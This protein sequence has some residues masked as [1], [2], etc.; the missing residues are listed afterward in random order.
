MSEHNNNNNNNTTTTTRVAAATALLKNGDEASRSLAQAYLRR[1]LAG[2]ISKT[3]DQSSTHKNKKNKKKHTPSPYN[4]FSQHYRTTHDL[5]G[6][7]FGDQ[8]KAIAA[9]WKT[10]SEAD[11]AHFAVK[12]VSALVDDHDHDDEH[13]ESDEDGAGGAAGGAG[14]HAPLSDENADL[15]ARFKSFVAAKQ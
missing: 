1:I 15:L 14:A 8:A 7:S 12:K 5:A 13:E 4:R 11:K 6:V 9:E 3:T 2:G 10:M